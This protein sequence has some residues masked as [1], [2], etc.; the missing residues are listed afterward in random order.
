MTVTVYSYANCSTCKKAL[1]YL[2]KQGIAHKTVDITT[3]PP[4][5]KDLKGMLA[6]YE[7]QVKKLFN[8]SGQAYRE[9]ELGSKLPDMTEAAA[10]KL[11]AGNGRLIKRP[12]LIVGGKPAAVGFDQKVW[13]EVLR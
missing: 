1:K 9:Q 4:P 8:T 10:L 6:A 2:E 13:D 11:L 5:L 3:T 7:G 12:F